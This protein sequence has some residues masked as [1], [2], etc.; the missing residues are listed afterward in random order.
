MSRFKHSI[1]LRLVDDSIEENNIGFG[2][3]DHIYEKDTLDSLLNTEI[4]LQ[5]VVIF[6]NRIDVQKWESG[7]LKFDIVIYLY[8]LNTHDECISQTRLDHFVGCKVVA[9]GIKYDN[10]YFGVKVDVESR[11]ST[12]KCIPNKGA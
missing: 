2:L 5:K 3:I 7:E 12:P 1:E 11:N 4:C 10:V 6:Q 9:Y 8:G